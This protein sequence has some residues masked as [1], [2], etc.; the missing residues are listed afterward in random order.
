M[1][2]MILKWYKVFMITNIAKY[3]YIETAKSKEN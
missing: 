3:F 2:I 1:N